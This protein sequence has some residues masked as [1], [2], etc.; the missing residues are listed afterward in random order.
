M[1]DAKKRYTVQQVQ[2]HRWV[3]DGAAGSGESVQSP[4]SSFA[5]L[6]SASLTVSSTPASPRNDEWNEQILQL[7]ASKGIDRLKTLEVLSSRI[8]SFTLLS[9]P[10]FMLKNKSISKIGAVCNIAY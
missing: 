10:L 3:Q 7:M 4:P 9:I 5:S 6:A 2:Q 1:L 8:S